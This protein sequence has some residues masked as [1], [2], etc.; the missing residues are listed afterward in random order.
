MFDY[1]DVPS[2]VG[3]GEPEY[4]R[5]SLAGATAACLVPFPSRD[6]LRSDF[7]CLPAHVYGITLEQRVVKF[8]P[9]SFPSLLSGIPTNM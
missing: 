5:T 8:T 2:L 4:W 9:N 1:L 6:R 3:P 7:V